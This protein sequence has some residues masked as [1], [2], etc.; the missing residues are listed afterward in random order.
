[1]TSTRLPR[2]LRPLDRK[3]SLLHHENCLKTGA[4]TSLRTQQ[5]LIPS[6]AVRVFVCDPSVFVH[7][8]PSFFTLIIHTPPSDSSWTLVS[9]SCGIT[10]CK[11][12]P[13]PDANGTKG[14]CPPSNCNSDPPLPF[15]F[16]NDNIRSYMHCKLQ[17]LFLYPPTVQIGDFKFDHSLLPRP[18]TLPYS[19]FDHLICCRDRRYPY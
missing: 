12:A 16:P 11:I 3:Q 4:M 8:L 10:P 9:R 6:K 1:M 18:S 17:N 14:L 7:F 19:Q 13:G 2:L 15:S 5:S